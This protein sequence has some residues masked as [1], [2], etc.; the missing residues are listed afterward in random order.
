MSSQATFVIDKSSGATFKAM[1]RLTQT[2]RSTHPDA[3]AEYRTL[4]DKGSAYW[5][6][7]VTFGRPL[8]RV[9]SGNVLYAAKQ[10]ADLSSEVTF[11]RL[12]FS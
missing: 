4:L 7:E 6:C 2:I 10:A 8:D 3:A 1:H 11:E 5:Q 12:Q 9:E